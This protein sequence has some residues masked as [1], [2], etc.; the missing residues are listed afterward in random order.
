[1]SSIAFS[2]VV[3]NFDH[4]HL[5][6]PPTTLDQDNEKDSFVKKSTKHL[7]SLLSPNL[8]TRA[9]SRTSLFLY[10]ANLKLSH[11][12][13]T[14]KRI[15]HPLFQE[16]S[17]DSMPCLLFKLTIHFC[18]G[19]SVKIHFS[20]PGISRRIRVFVVSMSLAVKD[21]LL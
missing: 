13:I 3:A 5:V 7:N 15:S 19:S 17:R 10:P 9:K 21:V 11:R 1:M 16:F 18:R 2:F 8:R 14:H 20:R 6:Q 4:H 12:H